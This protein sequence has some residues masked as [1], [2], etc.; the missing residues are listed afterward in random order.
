VPVDLQSGIFLVRA[1]GSL[2]SLWPLSKPADSLRSLACRSS[3]VMGQSAHLSQASATKTVKRLQPDRQA[4]PRIGATRSRAA[5]LSVRPFVGKL[6]RS[7]RQL[8]CDGRRLAR[9]LGNRRL[10]RANRPA[11]SEGL[12]ERFAVLRCQRAATA[13]DG[14]R[15]A[16]RF[17]PDKPNARASVRR[18]SAETK[19]HRGDGYRA[20][21]NREG[22]RGSNS[23][24]R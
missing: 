23:R 1:G 16:H 19:T 13:L 5:F 4:T 24:T 18:T 15:R 7:W 9:R 22:S 3:A 8:Q 10:R 17:R 12:E 21:T 2:A 20:G 6:L 11:G 14:R